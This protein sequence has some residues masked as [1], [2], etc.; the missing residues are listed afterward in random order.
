MIWASGK[1]TQEEI[2]GWVDTMEE[3]LND[4]QG[5]EWKS[6]MG[7]LWN[8]KL[9]GAIEHAT[10]YMVTTKKTTM[11]EFKC[12]T[13]TEDGTTLNE[14]MD[15]SN[16]CYNDYFKYSTPENNSA[17]GKKEPE[18]ERSALIKHRIR[19]ENNSKTQTFPVF[20]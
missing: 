17:A 3:V 11:E 8:E 2:D 6:K 1:T 5:E 12:E 18:D 7:R 19:L 15:P 14:I 9:G 16:S 13:N 10:E 4:R 20:G